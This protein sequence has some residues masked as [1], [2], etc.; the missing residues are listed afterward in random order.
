M[1]AQ[2]FFHPYV[3]HKA[4]HIQAR[5]AYLNDIDTEMKTIKKMMS[6]YSRLLAL[7]SLLCLLHSPLSSQTIIN[8]TGL[9]DCEL[10]FE[11]N[12]DGTALKIDKWQYRTDSKHWSTQLP[13]NVEVKNGYLYLNVKK[14]TANGMNYTGAGVI[15]KPVYKFG[16]YESRFKIPAG[17]GWHTSFWMMGYD[18][19]GGTST[20]NAYQELDV[21]ENDS[22][23]YLSY[24]TNVHNWLGTHTSVNAANVNTPDLR[25]DFHTWGCEFTPSF[26]KFYFEGNLVRTVDVSKQALND[27][28]IWLT[29]LGSS[30]GG[31]TAIDDTQLPSA[32]VI[33]Y[34]RYY[35]QLNPVF[36]ET[37]PSDTS[38]VVPNATNPQIIIDNTDAACTFDAPWTV[39]TYNTGFYGTNYANDGTAADDPA[40]WAKWTP[41]VPADAYYNI[42]MRWTAGANRPS[43]VPLEIQHGEGNTTTKVDQTINNASWRFLGNFLLLKGSGSYV[44]ISAS[45]LGFTVADAV[46]FEQTPIKTGVEPQTAATQFQI[47]SNASNNKMVATFE[48]QDKAEITLQVYNA[49]GILVNDVLN[50]KVLE[51]GMQSFLLTNS[52]MNK[53]F[54]IAVLKLNGKQIV[55]QRFLL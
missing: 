36:P 53:G 13:E 54:Y 22:K 47:T 34:V 30:L 55:C 3:S 41:L 48:I 7:C 19:S 42:F 2:N 31:T 18:G 46:L 51:S 17:N 43:A 45:A 35:K 40:K 25:A 20:T 38:K 23:N 27:N 24:S 32:A 50:G 9:G 44:K 4:N 28:N 49:S 37:N 6:N 8:R 26:V 33:D 1:H 29:T 14:Q 39:S 10:T 5:W 15:S 21:C 12:F 16:Y 11:D 52:A